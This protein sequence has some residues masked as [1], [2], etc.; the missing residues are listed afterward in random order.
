MILLFLTTLTG[1]RK[2][3]N[4][5]VFTSRSKDAAYKQELQKVIDQKARITKRRVKITAQMKLLEERA[6]K[7]LPPNA[8]DEQVKAELERNPAKYPGWNTLS[9][10]LVKVDAA[11]EKELA[12][13]RALVR[14]RI[15]AEASSGKPAAAGKKGE[16]PARKG[17]GSK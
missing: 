6:R 15:S 13:A 10:E 8:T 7:N 14:R 12:D 5:P 3:Q 2:A 11:M 1:C 4:P 16:P 17:A 9:A